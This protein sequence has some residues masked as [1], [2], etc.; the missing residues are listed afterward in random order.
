M[1]LSIATQLVIHLTILDLVPCEDACLRSPPTSQ[2]LK[3]KISCLRVSST[4]KTY[5]NNP[6]VGGKALGSGFHVSKTP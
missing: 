3:D 1:Y 5:S 4:T 2:G 6:G